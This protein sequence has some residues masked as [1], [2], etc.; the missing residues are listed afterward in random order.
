M[1]LW[2]KLSDGF[3]SVLALVNKEVYDQMIDV[4]LKIFD[5]IEIGHFK[6]MTV[7]DKALIML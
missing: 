2:L 4:E 7:K 1:R 5:I 3:S 6:W